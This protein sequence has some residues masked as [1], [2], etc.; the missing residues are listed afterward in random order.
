MA[1]R[2]SKLSQEDRDIAKRWICDHICRGYTLYVM[3]TTF[4]PPL[5]M[6]L[7]FLLVVS[8]LNIWKVTGR[9]AHPEICNGSLSMFLNLFCWSFEHIEDK[10][11]EISCRLLFFY[12]QVIFPRAMSS[13]VQEQTAI[14]KHCD[15]SENKQRISLA[16]LLVWGAIPRGALRGKGGKA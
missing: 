5:W 6:A 2:L 3:H 11:C 16:A 8:K 15:E 7:I 13:N 12:L 14:N 9:P 10:M 1:T 4:F